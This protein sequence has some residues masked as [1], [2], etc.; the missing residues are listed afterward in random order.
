MLKESQ[1]RMNRAAFWDASM[2]RTPH[3]HEGLIGDHADD[4]A[5]DPGQADD[6][7]ARPGLL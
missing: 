2:S 1:K 5:A 3:E 7:V 6:D 4:L